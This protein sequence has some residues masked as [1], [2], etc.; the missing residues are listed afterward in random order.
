MLCCGISE[1]YSSSDGMSETRR[2]SC[3]WL[4][5]LPYFPSDAFGQRGKRTS[6]GRMAFSRASAMMQFFVT[7]QGYLVV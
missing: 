7:K 4:E 5:A 6:V 1:C 3:T 2:P